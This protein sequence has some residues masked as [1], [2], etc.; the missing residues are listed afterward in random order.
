MPF[1]NDTRAFG[2]RINTNSLS[3]PFHP[4]QRNTSYNTLLKKKQLLPV[5]STRH[6]QRTPRTPTTTM[7]NHDMSQKKQA[8]EA[9]EP[10]AVACVRQEDFYPERGTITS[11][12]ATR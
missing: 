2:H 5:R 6:T 7:P 12:E 8:A 11:V 10:T 9:A 4:N 1:T 3:Q